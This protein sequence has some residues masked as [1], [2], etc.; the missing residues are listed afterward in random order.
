MFAIEMTHAALDGDAYVPGR[1]AVCRS[2]ANGSGYAAKY[3]P[4]GTPIPY[5][6][7]GD[8]WDWIED[9]AK[10]VGSEI[11]DGV[12]SAAH[13]VADQGCVV[14]AAVGGGECIACIV[15]TVTDPA[16]GGGG[17]ARNL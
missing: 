7:G 11:K 10:W 3:L 14:A 4:A 2:Y 1:S 5:W 9:K 17:D 16:T 6:F 13:W 15:S 12:V 8:A